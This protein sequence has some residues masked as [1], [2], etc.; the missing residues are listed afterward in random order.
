MSGLRL[1][2][3]L[4]LLGAAVLVAAALTWVVPAG[5][6]DRKQDATTGRTV[7]V[8]GTFHAV[9]AA[10][11]GPFA[12]AVAIPRGFVEAADVVAVVVFVG[13]AWVLVD[14]LG[15]LPDAVDG[16]VALFADKGILLVP[17]VS[18]FF[19]SMG[20]LENMQVEIIPLV[21]GLVALGAGVGIDS[22]GVV[23]MSAGAAMVG[24]GEGGN[25]MECAG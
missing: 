5:A 11:V 22:L 1:P 20:A 7:V 14:R 12:A 4:V 15:A 25:N 17:I 6:Y 18:L 23:A 21:P 16:L 10:P 24:S 3:P 8:P 2:H 19:A 9:S 13:G